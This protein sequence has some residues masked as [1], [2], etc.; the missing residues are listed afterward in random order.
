MFAIFCLSFLYGEQ[1]LISKCL[2]VTRRLV[3][4]DIKKAKALKGVVYYPPEV[5]LFG[6]GEATEIQAG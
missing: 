6:T 4:E 1:T 3:S 5:A 2:E